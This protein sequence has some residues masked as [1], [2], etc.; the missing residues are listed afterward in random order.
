MSDADSSQRVPQAWVDAC[1]LAEGNPDYLPSPM[2]RTLLGISAFGAVGVGMVFSPLYLVGN[3]VE[4]LTNDA[5]GSWLKAPTELGVVMFFVLG[6]LAL[7]GERNA[8]REDNPPY[9]EGDSDE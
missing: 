1:E 2:K 3:A 8:M 4:E 5:Y 6:F 9:Q 7:M